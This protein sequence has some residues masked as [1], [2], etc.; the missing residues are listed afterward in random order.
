ME[1]L[2]KQ[3]NIEAVDALMDDQNECKMRLV[4]R[5]AV[6]ESVAHLRGYGF[7]PDE[8]LRCLTRYFYVDLDILNEALATH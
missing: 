4:D 5:R 3:Q 7:Q 1:E 2:S 8:I 6:D